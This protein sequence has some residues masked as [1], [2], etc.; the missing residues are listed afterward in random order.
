[1][2][3]AV[4]PL[5]SRRLEVLPAGRPLGRLQTVGLVSQQG[6]A[7][8]S[9]PTPAALG[10]SCSFPVWVADVFLRGQIGRVS[11]RFLGLPGVVSG[12]IN[13]VS[14]G[15]FVRGRMLILVFLQM[16]T[17]VRNYA[18][19]GRPVRAV[20]LSFPSFLVRD[21]GLPVD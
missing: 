9:L 3:Q 21:V 15:L 6:P 17:R 8:V 4:V 10:V 13:S 12:C 16:F 5:A 18:T 2:V 19:Y 11:R 7:S 20:G 1:M 14:G